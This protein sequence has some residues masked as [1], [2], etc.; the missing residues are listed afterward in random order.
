MTRRRTRLAAA[1][2]AAL[3]LVSLAIGG[4]TAKSE[5]SAVRQATTRFHSLTQA[6]RAGYGAFPAGVPIA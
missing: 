3:A 6:G 1:A 2:L 5:L 4:A